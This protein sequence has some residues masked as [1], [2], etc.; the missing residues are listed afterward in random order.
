MKDFEIAIIKGFREISTPF[1]DTLLQI[2]TI[3]GEQYVL[4]AVL[5]FFYFIVDKKKG[6]SVAYA[7]FTSLGLNGAIKGIVKYER[8]FIYDTSYEPVRKETATGYSFPSGHT[9]GASVSYVSVAL[10][11]KKKWLTIS[12][13]ILIFLIGLSRIGLG[14]HFPKDVVFG[15]IFGIGC[16]FLC[17]YLHEKYA[18]TLKNQMILYLITFA[19]Y[20]PFIFIFYRSSFE[21]IKIYRDFYTSY[22]MF[23]GYILGVYLEGKFVDFDNKAS[24]KIRLIR[25]LG[26]I[27]FVV[28]T[29]FGLDK[30]FPEGYILLD[31]LRYFLVSFVTLG[32]YPLVF[33]NVLFKKIVKSPSEN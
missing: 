29:Q 1:I 27:I 23:G 22:A 15:W 4:I 13:F 30:V 3:L 26:A 28:I 10:L 16:A 18:K 12:V 31:V 7:I 6:Q 9:Q 25:L 11:E 33:K 32:L 17:T 19:I 2:I 21:D 5:A 14:V 24:L 20:F 8:P